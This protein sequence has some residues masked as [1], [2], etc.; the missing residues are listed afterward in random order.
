[1]HQFSCSQHTRKK[2]CHILKTNVHAN[3][4]KIRTSQC[5]HCSI[6]PI[7]SE[8][9]GRQTPPFI[10][11]ACDTN[12]HSCTD[13]LGCRHKYDQP[14]HTACAAISSIQLINSYMNEVI[15]KYTRIKDT[16]VTLKVAMLLLKLTHTDVAKRKPHNE[17]LRLF[18]RFPVILL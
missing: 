18:Y 2:H 10:D 11:A 5:C 9:Y 12:S 15:C 14:P 6:K 1:L 13:Q 4:K 8:T 17:T 3:R 7:T 16:K